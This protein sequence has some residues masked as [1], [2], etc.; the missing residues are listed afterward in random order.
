MVAACGNRY[1]CA[2]LVAEEEGRKHVTSFMRTIS[3]LDEALMNVNTGA[4]RIAGDWPLPFL[5]PFSPSLIMHMAAVNPPRGLDPIPSFSSPFLG[6]EGTWIPS[7]LRLPRANVGMDAHH[8]GQER[9][10]RRVVRQGPLLLPSVF[11]HFGWQIGI[12]DKV[13][14]PPSPGQN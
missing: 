8:H 6:A 1:R 2:V 11:A 13:I 9:R 3:L 4:S 5:F 7:R 12:S 10:Q 14:L